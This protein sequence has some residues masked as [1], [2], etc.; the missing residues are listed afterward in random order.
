M[1]NYN[2]NYQELYHHGIL[3][4]KWGVRRYQNPD[5]SY[6]A[7]GRKRYGYDRVERKKDDKARNQEMFDKAIAKRQDR[8]DRKV[9]DK[10]R[11]DAMYDKAIA[12][13][14]GYKQTRKISDKERSDAMFDKAIER[15]QNKVDRKVADKE[16]A[17]K[18]F[19]KSIQKRLD[20]ADTKK[21]ADKFEAEATFKERF[22]YNQATR[23][24][25]A[26]YVVKKNMP[27]EEAKKKAN[28]AAVR[29]TAIF[30]AAVAA[31]TIYKYV[32]D[33]RL[34]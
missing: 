27:V 22:L 12:K 25:A 7:A 5:G 20:K 24:L 23:K 14:E 26:K 3:G 13:R 33:N 11:S 28:R 19:D 9:A 17:G 4:Q 8:V 30:T 21:L 15:R 6:T 10:A 29:N 18:I 1:N 32:D 34:Y 31:A 16:R 2:S